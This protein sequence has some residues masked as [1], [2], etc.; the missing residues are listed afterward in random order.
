MSAPPIYVPLGRDEVVRCLGS[1]IPARVGRPF[2][3]VPADAEVQTGGVCVFP[4]EGRPGYLY[5]LLDGCIYEQD[6]GPI[7]E[8]LVALIPGSVLETVPGDV[9]PETPPASEEPPWGPA[10]MR[11]DAPT[12]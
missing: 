9:Q 12:E 10:A 7:D 4:I 5:Y 11:A 1:R 6:A 2:L 8:S 3:R